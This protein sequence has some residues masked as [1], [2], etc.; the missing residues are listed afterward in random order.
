MPDL[1]KIIE[2]PIITEKALEANGQ[3]RYAF[4]VNKAANK[5]Q[6]REAV[7]T[8]FTQP[9]GQPLVVTDVNT[10]N[11]KGKEKRFRAFGRASVGKTAGYKKAIVTLAEGQSIQIFEGV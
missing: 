1:Y 4:V 2:R 10:L 3:R 11:V 6:I 7:T 9:D 5:I 8:L